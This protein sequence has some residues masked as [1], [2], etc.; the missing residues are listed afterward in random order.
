MVLL[1][2]VGD[3]HQQRRTVRFVTQSL[4]EGTLPCA[5]NTKQEDA[6]RP[7]QG[8]ALPELPVQYADY[9]HW[10]RQWLQGDVLEAQIAYWKDQLDDVSSLQLPGTFPYL[11]FELLVEYLEALHGRESFDR[12]C[13]TL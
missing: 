10:Q 12:S 7:P 6:S 3:I 2:G 1:D 13:C 11:L 5:W 8:I 9:A 4:G